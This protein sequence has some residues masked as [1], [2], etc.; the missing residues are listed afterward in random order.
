MQTLRTWLEA[1]VTWRNALTALKESRYNRYGKTGGDSLADPGGEC[2][3]DPKQGGG[4]ITRRGHSFSAQVCRVRP[5]AER[6]ALRNA[7]GQF[8]ITN[9][10]ANQGEDK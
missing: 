8:A 6:N 3:P 7:F 1:F 9:I 5:E 2:H 10:P 4:S